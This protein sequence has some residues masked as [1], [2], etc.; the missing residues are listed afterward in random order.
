MTIEQLME[1]VGC[2]KWP[3]HWRTLYD[4]VAAEFQKNGCRYLTPEYYDEIAG[5]YGIFQERLPLYK[6][7]AAAVAADEHLALFF[8]APLRTVRPPMRKP[9]P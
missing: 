6:Q 4:A 3:E 7:A 9:S 2:S 8:V 5:K 1:E